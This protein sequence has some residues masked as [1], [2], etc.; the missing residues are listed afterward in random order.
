MNKSNNII[1]IGGV[2]GSGTRVVSQILKESGYFTGDD[3]NDSEDNLLFTLIFKRQNILTT[4]EDE[5]QQLLNIFTKLMATN[6]TL[7][8]GEYAI[9]SNLASED[10]TLHTKEWLQ[11]RVNKI[12]VGTQT[13][14]WGWKEPN[15]HII[16]ERL[17]QHIQN[18]KFIYVYRNGL[19]MAY[20]QNQNQL[21]LWGSIFFNNYDIDINPKNSLKYWCIVHKRMLK[22]Q[23]KYP[24]KILML[25]FDTLCQNPQETLKTFFNFIQ[26]N[27]NIKE[28]AKLIKAPS[29]IG[30]YKQSSLK[31]FN[32]D[33][34][35]FI[36]KL[37]NIKV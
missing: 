17:L 26:H 4:S 23:E 5:F 31:E 22:L 32:Q 24:D 2:G 33:D 29:S 14:L 3:I 15:T 35:D 21:K 25:D 11:E 37:Y 36:S 16:I 20:S 28:L 7:D 27:A 10:R 9:V 12:K 19:D 30:R 34:I 13:T 1:S 8:S 6:Q 18:L